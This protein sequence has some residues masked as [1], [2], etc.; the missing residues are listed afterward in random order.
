MEEYKKCLDGE[1]YRKECD[2]S[3][4]R[5]LNQDMYLQRIQKSSLS[6][7]DDKRYAMKKTL[8]VHIGIRFIFSYKFL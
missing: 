5:S 3:I 1:S 2:N 4:L 7:F 6:L 8:K